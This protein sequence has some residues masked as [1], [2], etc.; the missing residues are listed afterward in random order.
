[1][2]FPA[3]HEEEVEHVY[4]SQHSK[5]HCPQRPRKES[6][7]KARLELVPK[8]RAERIQ[9]RPKRPS[10]GFRVNTLIFKSFSTDEGGC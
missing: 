6:D 10:D 2:L 1:M 9:S 3:T 8:E 5:Q 7:A 4:V